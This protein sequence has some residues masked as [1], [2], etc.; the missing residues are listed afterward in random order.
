MKIRKQRPCYEY[1]VQKS[2]SNWENAKDSVS[3]LDE[4]GY[5]GLPLG[6]TIEAA[7][8]GDLRV[9]PRYLGS[10]LFYPRGAEDQDCAVLKFSIE[11]RD[12][13]NN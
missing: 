13:G 6:G 1:L 10:E 7:R 3:F 11:R 4:A 8:D 5:R 12:A 9:K 2:P